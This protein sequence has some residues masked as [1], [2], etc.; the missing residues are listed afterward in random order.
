[1]EWCVAQ[2]ADTVHIRS[3]IDK[4]LHIVNGTRACSEMQNSVVHRSLLIRIGQIESQEV[5]MGFVFLENR[6]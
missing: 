2:V 1:M 5:R 4:Y 3:C 6:C